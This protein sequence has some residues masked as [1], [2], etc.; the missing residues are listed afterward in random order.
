MYF[1]YFIFFSFL[2]ILNCGNYSL[3]HD[4]D[5]K[6]INSLIE[7]YIRDNPKIIEK[8][9]QDLNSQRSKNNFNSAIS[10]L[11]KVSNPTLKNKNSNLI[12]YEFF[13]YNCGYCKSV[14]NSIFN[15]H[16]KD[17]KIDIVF[18]EYPILSNSSL[19]AAIASLATKEQGKYFKFH[20]K[21]MSH[22]G[23]I[24]EN[25]ILTIAKDLKIDIE[26]L[27]KDFTNKN[28]SLIINKNREIANRLNIRGTPAF[29]IGTTIYPGALSEQD[30]E[31]AIKIER[32]KIKM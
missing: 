2:F 20:R 22:T 28:L 1:K 8:S 31:K 32:K 14:M 24:D 15:V 27:K 23:K 10:D 6:K 21:L 17:K 16:K 7:Q 26:K 30:I 29:I 4:I 12:I 5:E 13:D 11:K 19:T 18:V 3:A 9:L 25:L